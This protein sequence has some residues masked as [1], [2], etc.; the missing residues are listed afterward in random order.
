MLHKLVGFRIAPYAI[1]I[2]CFILPFIQISCDGKKMMS[3]T[4]VQMVTGSEMANPMSEKTERIPSEPRA[5]IALIA[6]VAGVAFSINLTRNASIMSAV[7]GGVALISMILLKTTA[8]AEIMKQA[9]GMPIT[10]EY[11]LGFWSVCIMAIVGIILAL[12]RRDVKTAPSQHQLAGTPSCGICAHFQ[13]TGI[14][15]RF[16]GACGKHKKDTYTNWNCEDY[17]KINNS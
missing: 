4:G 16:K 8:D 12:M 7:A 6:L 5:I 17:T 15:D 10:V 9:S 11:Q 2:A 14:L 1:A 13:K 3:F